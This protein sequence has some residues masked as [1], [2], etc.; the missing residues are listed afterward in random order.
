MLPANL[1]YRNPQI[2]ALTS[3][4]PW[5]VSGSMR[6]LLLTNLYPRPHHETFAPFNRQQFH[7]LVPEHELRI[8]APVSWT[9]EVRDRLSGRT[10]T[11]TRQTLDGVTVEHPLYWFPPK[12]APHWY[13]QCFLWSVRKRVER[14]IR[15]FAPDLILSAWA[16]PDGWAAS[17]LAQ[18]AGLPSVVKVHG[19]D[20]LINAKSGPRRREIATGLQKASAVI[21]VSQDLKRRVI[22]L[23]VDPAKVL[24]FLEG[25]DSEK[26][27]PGCKSEAREKLRLPPDTRQILYVGNLLLSKGLGVLVEACKMLVSRSESFQCRIIGRGRQES[28]IRN[29]IRAAKLDDHIILMGPK[30]HSELPD[31]Y[32]ASDLFVL[33]SFS[34]GIPNVL[35]E[36]IACGC[37]IVSTRVGGIPEIAHRD[38]GI[39]VE[40]GDPEA[41]ADALATMLNNP[42][43]SDQVCS[44]AIHQTWAKTAQEMT[45]LFQSLHQR[46]VALEVG[47]S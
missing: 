43:S 33:P 7:A 12:I 15:E 37:P 38:A 19:S 14:V 40:P 23:G 21:T 25:I 31:W 20:V 44:T 34:E 42:R 29:L 6:I 8:I 35:R 10:S 13:G 11:Y 4:S 17:V 45:E 5:E 28:Q 41:L 9:E 39:L 36:S 22:E 1:S 32:R 18:E 30:P 26:F 24:V 46:N 3:Y 16:H 2:E 27:T 47:N